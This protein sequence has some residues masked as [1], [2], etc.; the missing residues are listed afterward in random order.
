MYTLLIMHITQNNLGTAYKYL[1]QNQ[2]KQANIMNASRAFEK[3]LAIFTIE[4]FPLIHQQIVSALE[5]LKQ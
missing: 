3:A 5:E 4:E 2:L 1:A